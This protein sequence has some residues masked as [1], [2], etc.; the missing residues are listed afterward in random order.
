MLHPSIRAYYLEAAEWED[1]WIQSAIE[2]AE[3]CWTNH[4][5]AAVSEQIAAPEMSQFA[6]SK[7]SLFSMKGQLY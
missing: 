5:K 7:V 1:V 4:Y 6:Y 2:I 3:K